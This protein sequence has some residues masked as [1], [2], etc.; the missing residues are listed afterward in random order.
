M[1]LRL[2]VDWC[3]RFTSPFMVSFSVYSWYGLFLKSS[4]TRGRFQKNYRRNVSFSTVQIPLEGFYSGMN[5][6]VVLRS[7]CSHFS[8]AQFCWWYCFLTNIPWFFL[9]G[10]VSSAYKISSYFCIST[11]RLFRIWFSVATLLATV[12]NISLSTTG[13]FVVTAMWPFQCCFSRFLMVYRLSG[14]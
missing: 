5:Q 14:K 3:K 12:A 6:Y 4:L 1:H 13:M 9:C 10:K 2:L 7:I 8:F 11:G